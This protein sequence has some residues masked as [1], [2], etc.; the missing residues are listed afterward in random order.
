MMAIYLLSLANYQFA[1]ECRK[2]TDRNRHPKFLLDREIV[3]VSHRKM[4]R[5]VVYDV[6]RTLLFKIVKFEFKRTKKNKM[7]GCNKIKLQT[8]T[9]FL[10]T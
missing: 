8:K 5:R 10:K 9:E 1:G 2:V 3:C 7:N 4:A 6:C